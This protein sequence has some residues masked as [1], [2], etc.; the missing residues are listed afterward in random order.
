MKPAFFADCAAAP[1]KT[2]SFYDA[3]CADFNFIFDYYVWAD[4]D[5]QK[6]NFGFSANNMVFPFNCNP[7]GAS[8]HLAAESSARF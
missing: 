2:K 6:A 5:I 1:E 4:E 7:A 3:V 8:T